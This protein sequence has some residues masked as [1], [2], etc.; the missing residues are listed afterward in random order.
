MKL[1]ILLV[2]LVNMFFYHNLYAKEDSDLFSIYGDF[3]HPSR[4]YLAP[5]EAEPIGGPV[6]PNF[7]GGGIS[8]NA[9]RIGYT[10]FFN[11]GGR[12]TFTYNFNHLGYVNP[13]L[14]GT[15]VFGTG[16]IMKFSKST[17]HIDG[18][19]P[20]IG[21]NMNFFQVL[22]PYVEYDLI[23][24]Y[25]LVGLRVAMPIK[26]KRKSEADILREQEEARKEWQE[27]QQAQSSGSG[28]SNSRPQKAR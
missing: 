24:N 13:Y 20:I 5:N 23:R 26:V 17:V 6:I 18:L 25:F 3:A 27:K 19:S 8:Y 4:T 10:S 15:Y 7:Y 28:R 1:K 21:I 22:K 11:S 12:F 14:G 2:I 9:L 16:A